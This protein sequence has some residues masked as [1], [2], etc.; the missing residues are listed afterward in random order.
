[1]GLKNGMSIT[2]FR[3]ILDANCARVVVLSDLQS[4]MGGLRDESMLK[5]FVLVRK[6]GMSL[7]I[8]D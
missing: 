8:Y 2:A 7:S 5:D 3:N 6:E 4:G 1:M